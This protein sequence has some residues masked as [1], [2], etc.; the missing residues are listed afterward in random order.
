MV[1]NP[2]HDTVNTHTQDNFGAH[3]QEEFGAHLN[4][5]RVDSVHV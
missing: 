1:E 2:A 5:L 3:A 4:P